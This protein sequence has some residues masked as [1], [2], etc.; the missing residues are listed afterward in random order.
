MSFS[1][2]FNHRKMDK[3]II[4]NLQDLQAIHSKLDN[5]QS[6]LL[7]GKTILTFDEVVTYTGLSKSYLYK[8]TSGG[9]IPHSKP[10]GKNLYFDKASIDTWLMRGQVKTAAEIDTEATRYVTLQKGV[11]R[12]NKSSRKL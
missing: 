12:S 2:L 6:A 10:N 8:L 5:I 1:D 7:S 9:I 11:I 3:E 4:V